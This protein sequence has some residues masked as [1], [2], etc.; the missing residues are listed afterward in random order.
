MLNPLTG[1]RISRPIS[2]IL[3]TLSA[4]AVAAGIAHFLVHIIVPSIFILF[5]PVVAIATAYGGLRYGLLATVLS[6]I[7]VHFMP[8]LHAT[9]NIPNLA[10]RITIFILVAFTVSLLQNKKDDA[11]EKMAVLL[12]ESQLN[13]TR[14]KAVV[15]GLADFVWTATP[16]GKLIYT[17]NWDEWVRKNIP[18][19]NLPIPLRDIPNMDYS[20]F[21]HKTDK[22]RVMSAWNES[23]KS[24]KPF[25]ITYRRKGSTEVYVRVRAVPVISDGKIREWVGVS[26]DVTDEVLFAK[27]RENYIN[28]IKEAKDLA[29]A[30]NNAKDQFLA[31]LSHEL[32]TPLVSIL[33]YTNM[34]S[35]GKLTD[36]QMTRAVETINR[37]AKL[38]VELIEDLLDISRVMAGKISLQKEPLPVCEVIK[39]VV[40]AVSPQAIEKGLYLKIDW[41]DTN[42][43]IDGDR[44][45]IAQMV[46]N[47]LTNAI[48]FTDSGGITVCVD[49]LENIDKVWICVKDTGI[50]IRKEVMESLFQ[51]FKQADSSSTRRYGGLGLGLS[52]VRTLTDLHGGKVWAESEEEGKGSTFTIELPVIKKPDNVIVPQIEKATSETISPLSLFGLTLLI[53][54][55]D[56][57]TR[58][59]LG[60][61]FKRYGAEIICAESAKDA[62]EKVASNP[63][64]NVY[65]FDIGMP[66][67]D[68]YSLI[69]SLREAGNKTPALALTAFVGKEYEEA[70]LKAGFNAYIPKPP[71]MA[72]LVRKVQ[73]L[74][75]K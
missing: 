69:K 33:G 49:Y 37:N 53:T 61:I 40:D 7:V 20:E 67:E 25:D 48:K 6:I 50:G 51:R 30:A 23:L 74:S 16:E 47:L 55:D 28:E 65:I 41:K 2:S 63:Q 59:L 57:D 39:E 14:Y 54:D 71:S 15:D 58:Y 46:M 42:I 75:G 4:L 35:S 1:K 44:R 27:E 72:Y 32:R 60:E 52:I 18:H 36:E 29:E 26:M 45:R 38:Q 66:D 9:I 5:I 64:V 62:R 73:D 12:A 3:I 68:G 24:G 31:T 43:Y 10:I 22:E 13:E 11:E 19:L 21:V 8:E 70:A 34:I 56:D 17:P